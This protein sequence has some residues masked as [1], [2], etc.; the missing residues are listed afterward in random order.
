MLFLMSLAVLDMMSSDGVPLD[1]HSALRLQVTDSVTLIRS[2]GPD[3]YKNNLEQQFSTMV[4]QAV[5]KHGMNETAISTTAID[6]IDK[7]TGAIENTAKWAARATKYA[8]DYEPATV[9]AL[10]T[11]ARRPSIVG[12]VTS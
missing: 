8:A 12:G 5:R 10:T 3:W 2:F 4:R 11:A 7:I 6:S 9:S 1:F